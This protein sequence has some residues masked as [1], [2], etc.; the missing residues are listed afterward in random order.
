MAGQKGLP[1]IDA[2]LVREAWADLQQ[3]PPSPEAS[4]FETS[5]EGIIEFG[6]LDDNPV[7]EAVGDWEE[8]SSDS[9]AS[10]TQGNQASANADQ[11]LD[12]LMD[13]LESINSANPHMH[14]ANIVESE[15]TPP[16][17]Q[18]ADCHE[19]PQPPNSME[20]RGQ[21]E[22]GTPGMTFD[23]A[24]TEQ[25]PMREILSAKARFDT[26]LPGVPATDTG[27]NQASSNSP[28]SLDQ[29]ATEAV[30][31]RE[32]KWLSSMEPQETATVQ[33]ASE[34]P[35]PLNASTLP[36]NREEFASLSDAIHAPKVPESENTLAP[37]E[38]A[39]DLFGDT[40]EEENIVD[41]QTSLLAEQNR[42]SSSMSTKELAELKKVVEDMRDFD[43][44][45]PVIGE[46]DLATASEEIVQK[47]EA[48]VPQVEAEHSI[49]EEDAEVPDL[50]QT[51]PLPRFSFGEEV[52]SNEDSTQ[53]DDSDML[54][55]EPNKIVPSENQNTENDPTTS[56][57]QVVRMNYEDLFQ[58]LRN[59]NNHNQNT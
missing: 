33:Q 5:T 31:L 3:L 26:A 43:S 22:S 28:Q 45:K 6:N 4:S 8:Q 50:T 25:L 38:A 35:F 52:D 39:D 19:S 24:V 21:C 55:C 29:A 27:S 9:R 49:P 16:P 13:H 47:I 10:L 15:D 37:Q 20:L 18:K 56:Q 40:F 59:N 51:R 32:M 58:Q 34:N 30:P 7:K 53:G 57:G 42:I 44:T 23:A 54:V 41:L 46:I 14:D 11:T 12:V 48:V 17:S 36:G 1:Q 2:V